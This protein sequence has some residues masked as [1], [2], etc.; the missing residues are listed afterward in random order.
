MHNFLQANEIKNFFFRH[1]KSKIVVL[2]NNVG[3]CFTCRTSSI[4][5]AKELVK[6]FKWEKYFS[7]S[8]IYPGCKL[9]HFK[10]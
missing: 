5:E 6:L 10:K 2:I 4:E 7:Y 1:L 3:S 9:N 8:E